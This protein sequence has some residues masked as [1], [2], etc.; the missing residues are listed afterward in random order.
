MNSPTAQ[1]TVATRATVILGRPRWPV[2]VSPSYTRPLHL[3]P[4]SGT[5]RL[6]CAALLKLPLEPS[7]GLHNPTQTEPKRPTTSSL[8]P[9]VLPPT[10]TS[11]AL[12]S[13]SRLRGSL[14]SYPLLAAAPTLYVHPP[15]LFP[16]KISNL[17]ELALSLAFPRRYAIQSLP[18]EV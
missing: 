7:A 4:S 12:T 18:F 3:P 2:F 9:L 14:L 5:H 1:C 11:L 10:T 6:E 15:P 8:C 16:S 17:L 13:L